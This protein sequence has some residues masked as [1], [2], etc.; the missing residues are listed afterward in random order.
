MYIS[1]WE[2][3]HSWNLHVIGLWNFA[4]CSFILPPHMFCKRKK[5]ILHNLPNW[6]SSFS[7][8][9]RNDL[10]LM[11]L[12]VIS[13]KNHFVQRRPLCTKTQDSLHTK[14]NSYDWEGPF[15]TKETIAYK[16]TRNFVLK[17]SCILRFKM[18]QISTCRPS[19]VLCFL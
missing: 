12:T 3:D 10:T 2:F 18:L 11:W 9:V 14:T 19:I 17:F 13:Y 1:A 5:C 8:F 15:C 4:I 7:Y 16:Y 6:R